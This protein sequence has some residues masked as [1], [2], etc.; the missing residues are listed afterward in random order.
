MRQV[1]DR[2]ACESEKAFQRLLGA[3]LVKGSSRDAVA[4]RCE[5]YRSY[6]ERHI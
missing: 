5:L 2:G 1:L 6:F 4:P 3:G